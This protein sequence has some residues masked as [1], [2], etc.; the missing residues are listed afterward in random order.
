MPA[1]GNI[2]EIARALIAPKNGIWAADES[3]KTMSE[4]FANLG[5]SPLVEH[6][7]EWRRIICETPGV[8]AFISGVILNPE[9]LESPRRDGRQFST[10][11]TE[12]NIIPGV[13]VDTGL[14]ENPNAPGEKLTQGLDGLGER[15]DQYYALGGRF[16]KWRTV[17]DIGPNTPSMQNIRDNANALA[18]YAKRGQEHGLLPI[19]EPEILM[20][21]DHTLQR[22]L[23]VTAITLQEVFSELAKHHVA[24]NGILL[25]PNM[26]IPGK[27]GPQV[28]PLEVA[29]ATIMAL[30]WSVPSEVPGI[31]FLSGGQTPDQATE[32]LYLINQV[33]EKLNVPWQLSFSYGRALQNEALIRFGEEL[34]AVK[35]ERSREINESAVQKAFFRRAQLVSLARNGTYPSPVK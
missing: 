31:V 17:I 15:L 12:A 30:R 22:S 34:K 21:G 9:T 11:L 1:A 35:E 2:Q 5:I 18:K 7:N 8:A 24:L 26:V 25:K 6:R 16:V 20:H 4:R 10:I 29:E 13:K 28:T 23:Q 19:V 3:P 33:G 14:Q 32:H 27:E